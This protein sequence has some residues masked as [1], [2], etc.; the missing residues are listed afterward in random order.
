MSHAGRLAASIVFLALL[1]ALG[2]AAPRSAPPDAPESLRTAEAA[3]LRA[4][5][6]TLDRELRARDVS[7]LTAAQRA[8]RARHIGVLRR[9]AA[10]GVFPH[11]HDFPGR[12]V[13]FFVDEHGTL[14]AMAYLIARSGGEDLVERIR[15][16]RNRAYIPELAGDPELRAWLEQAGLTLEEAARIQPAYRGDPVYEEGSGIATGYALA[17]V[18]LGAL[19]GVAI[20][21]NLA[22]EP[23]QRRWPAALGVV[24]GVL[25]F[26]LGVLEI[27]SDD[28]AAALGAVNAGVGL[29]STGLGMWR[30]LSPVGDARGQEQ[31][32]RSGAVLSVAPTVTRAGEAALVLRLVF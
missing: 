24:T 25:G 2:G 13:P 32:A 17:S 18:G 14:C 8:A 27:D 3:R 9:Y 5:F 23:A 21:L 10:A 7:Q 12:M 6:A 20:A 19:S 16:T 4:H 26:G 31:A 15:A 28:G 1:T 22:G 29:A 11:N 30:L